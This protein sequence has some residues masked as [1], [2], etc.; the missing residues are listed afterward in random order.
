MNSA[1]TELHTLD[2]IHPAS[3]HFGHSP[4]PPDVRAVLTPSHLPDLVLSH[5]EISVTP[6]ERDNKLMTGPHTPKRNSATGH[7]WTVRETDTSGP[8][9]H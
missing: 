8:P 7:P 5:T 1:T 6:G 4:A 9:A 2:R 3:P